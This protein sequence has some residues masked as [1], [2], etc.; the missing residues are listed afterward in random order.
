MYDFELFHEVIRC[1]RTDPISYF[2]PE[3]MWK[4]ETAVFSEDIEKT[5]AFVETDCSDEEFFWLSEVMGDI[6]EQT[7]S[8]AFAEALRLRLEKVEDPDWK[9][10]IARGVEEAEKR[11]KSA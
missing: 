3:F 8:A 10:D 2:Y 9:E 4:Q 11:V 6:A 7:G 5:I 1:R